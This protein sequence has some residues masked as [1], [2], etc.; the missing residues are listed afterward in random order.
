[1][2]AV[3]KTRDQIDGLSRREFLARVGALG[4]LV[5]IAGAADVV[6]AEE[7]KKYGAD[8]MP[9]GW[10]DNPLAFIAI[11]D[12]G[13][14]TIVVHRSEMGQGVRTGMPLIVADE[15][16]ADWSKVRVTQAPADEAKF[17]NQDT[18][19]SRSTRHFFE[20]MRRC[21]AAAR[22]MLEQAAAAGW[23]VSVSEVQAVN[24]EVVHRKSGRRLGYGALARAAARLPVPARESLRLKDPT[25]FRYIG[26]GRTHLADGRDIVVGKAQ[27]GIDTRL[28]GMLY[29]VVARSPVLGGK[30]VR[31]D[32]AEALKIPGVVK[33][34]QIQVSVPSAKFHPLNG[35][36]Y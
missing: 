12:D 17:G 1:M 33:V 11:G 20:P 34:L 28:D 9:H 8:S 14:V 26:K 10:S 27:Y 7:V 25:R 21:G 2:S 32:D 31:Y 35:V 24:H 13:V 18:D 4:G 29:A 16:E 23:G 3:M 15:L 6:K 22:T 30:V 36:N 19:G 5:L